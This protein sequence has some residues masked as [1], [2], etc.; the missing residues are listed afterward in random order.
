LN[1]PEQLC[2]VGGAGVSCHDPKLAA[3]TRVQQPVKEIG[4]ELFLLAETLVTEPGKFQPGRYLPCGLSCGDT[5]TSAENRRL[6]QTD[7][8]N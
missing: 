5:T 3:M 4:H 6:S 8:Q 2:V 1:V 7:R